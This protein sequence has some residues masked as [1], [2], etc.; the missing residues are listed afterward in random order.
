[1]KPRKLNL[2][3]VGIWSLALCEATAVFSRNIQYPSG[4][5]IVVDDQQQAREKFTQP[6]GYPHQSVL[7]VTQPYIGSEYNIIRIQKPLQTLTLKYFREVT[8]HS[9]VN[10]TPE[11]KARSPS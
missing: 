6:E 11:A 3:Y 8:I 1:M 4:E 2:A 5:L 9:G 10:K 7:I